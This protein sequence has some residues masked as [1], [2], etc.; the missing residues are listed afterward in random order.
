MCE[1]SAPGLRDGTTTATIPETA[2]GEADPSFGLHEPLSWYQACS[3][4][5]RNRGLYIADQNLGGAF[6]ES[7]QRHLASLMVGAYPSG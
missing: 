7:E 1:D 2:A 5:S 6:V 3:N 4:R